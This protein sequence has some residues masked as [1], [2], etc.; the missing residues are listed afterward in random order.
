LLQFYGRKFA[1]VHFV[2][3]SYFLSPQAIR[4]RCQQNVTVENVAKP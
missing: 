4:K 2:Y 1:E 3:K